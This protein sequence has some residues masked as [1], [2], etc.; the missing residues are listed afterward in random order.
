MVDPQ[1]PGR[2][3]HLDRLP[4]SGAGGTSRV[5]ARYF[6]KVAKSENGCWEW[7]GAVTSAGYGSFAVVTTPKPRMVSAHKAHWEM[8]H[9]P[10]PQ[11][12]VL[13]H[14]CDNRTCVR[15]DH[16]SLGTVDDNNQDMVRK[17]R[18]RHNPYPR[19]CGLCGADG[20]NRRTCPAVARTVAP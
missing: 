15:L 12:M 9:G 17:G 3:D 6:S 5:R 16:L 19:A 11:G 4:A 14:S 8:V 18:H 1:S 2:V 10:V 20:H 7:T 13:M